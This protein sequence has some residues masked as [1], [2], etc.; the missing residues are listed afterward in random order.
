VGFVKRNWKLEMN[1]L[2]MSKAISWY[3]LEDPIHQLISVFPFGKKNAAL[4]ANSSSAS[5]TE[6]AQ[7]QIQA[8]GMRVTIMMRMRMKVPVMTLQTILAQVVQTSD[9]IITTTTKIDELGKT[10][11]KPKAT[12]ARTFNSITTAMSYRIFCHTSLY[13]VCTPRADRRDPLSR[14]DHNIHIILRDDNL[15]TLAATTTTSTVTNLKRKGVAH[16]RTVASCS[17]IS[18]PIC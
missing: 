5:T 11:R 6:E 18:E 10:V 7:F 8:L 4:N 13:Q 2:S 9:R 17:K 14:T 3:Y 1:I 16:I 15:R 12:M